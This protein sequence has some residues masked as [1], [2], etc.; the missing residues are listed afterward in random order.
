[1]Q[2]KIASSEPNEYRY[3]IFYEIVVYRTQYRRVKGYL[4]KQPNSDP[5]ESFPD[6]PIYNHIYTNEECQSQYSDATVLSSDYGE[7]ASTGACSLTPAASSQTT[8]CSAYNGQ[9]NKAPDGYQYCSGSWDATSTGE[10]NTPGSGSGATSSET[11]PDYLTPIDECT[12]YNCVTI[13]GQTYE[14][15]QSAINEDDNVTS[16]NN[17]GTTVHFYANGGFKLTQ[18]DGSYEITDAQGNTTYHNADGSIDPNGGSDSGSDGGDSGSPTDAG[19]IDFS[20]SDGGGTTPGTSTDEEGNPEGMGS[21]DGDSTLGDVVGAITNLRNSLTGTLQEGFQGVV[22]KLTST[23]GMP[24]EADA[25]AMVDGEGASDDV[26]ETLQS[27]YDETNEG[28]V[29]D[30]EGVFKDDGGI[31]GQA[32]SEV[33]DMATS[34]LPSIPSGGC[35]P[36]VFG[37]G[38]ASFTIPCKVFDMIKAAL[39]WILF[40]FTVYEVTSIGLGYRNNT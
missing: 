36:L 11:V 26:M 34:L 20:D 13:D 4:Y 3:Y 27:Q 29:E 37:S 38:D 16:F 7:T 9:G 25:I 5:V 40:F 6:S 19:D 21:G 8:L 22:D 39:S 17:D 1:M 2:E 23:D 30:Y 14:V 33:G 31:L 12:S 18:P 24:S 35:A 28:L 10:V 32:L 15:D